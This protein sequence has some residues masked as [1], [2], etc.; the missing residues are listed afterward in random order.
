MVFTSISPSK[1]QLV[2]KQILYFQDAE[3]T[4]WYRPNPK[5][6]QCFSVATDLTKNKQTF[7]AISLQSMRSYIKPK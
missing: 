2:R 3:V 7:N 1:K 4:I 6:L 5:H